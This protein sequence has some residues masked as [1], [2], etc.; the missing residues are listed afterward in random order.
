MNKR[1]R[2]KQAKKLWGT[3]RW[4]EGYITLGGSPVPLINWQRYMHYLK[5]A[6]VLGL[7][8]DLGSWQLPDLD[9][10]CLP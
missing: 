4:V 10:S 7:Q 6:E 1:Q 9:R 2:R 8:R 5:A 3:P